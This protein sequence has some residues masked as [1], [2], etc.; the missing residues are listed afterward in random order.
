M[1]QEPALDAEEAEPEALGR[2]FLRDPLG[3]SEPQTFLF[4]ES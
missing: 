1:N 3:S 2:A 4:L